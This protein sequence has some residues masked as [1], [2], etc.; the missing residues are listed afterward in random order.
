MRALFLALALAACA[1]ESVTSV[2]LSPT[3]PEIEAAL[4]AADA[5]WEAAGVDPDRIVIALGGA[6]VTVVPERCA[7][8][9][10]VSETRT[11]MQAFAF[12]G[13]RW[14]EL[15]NLDSAAVAH[16]VGHALGIEFHPDGDPAADPEGVELCAP[17]AADRPLMCSH[18]GAQITALDVSDA[19]AAGPCVGF[20]PEG[21]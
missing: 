16:E 9:K 10:C 21:E 7:G 11:H 1:P 18:A 19:C 6:P 8:G 2:T 5:R 15:A 12:R 17:G 3:S 4:R 13:V 14:I 20:R